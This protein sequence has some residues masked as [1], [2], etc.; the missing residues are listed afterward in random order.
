[1]KRNLGMLA[2]FLPVLPAEGDVNIHL[3]TFQLSSYY[4]TT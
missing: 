4:I 2:E 3:V 1:M